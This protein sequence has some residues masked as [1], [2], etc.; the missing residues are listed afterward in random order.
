MSYPFKLI[1]LLFAGTLLTTGC[2]K[3]PDADTNTEPATTAVKTQHDHQDDEHMKEEHNEQGHREGEH[4]GHDNHNAHD[5]HNN[6]D[7][8]EGHDHSDM[9]MT[10]YHCKP[11]QEIKAHYEEGSSAHLLID[12][13]EYDMT[14]L[15]STLAEDA[16]NAVVYETD[17][18]LNDNAGMMWQVSGDQAKLVT[19]T[20]DGSIKSEKEAVL[21][22]CQKS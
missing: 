2:Q 5:E 3:S 1:A 20:L 15:K 7:G 17:I 9:A 16:S 14:A 13:I 22:D 21:F 19:K 4:E 12:G 10:T 18:G 6:H 11:E 8:H